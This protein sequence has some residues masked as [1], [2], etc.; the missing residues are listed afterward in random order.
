M[1]VSP[2]HGQWITVGLVCVSMAAWAETE[3]TPEVSPTEIIRRSHD[4][5][6]DQSSYATVAMEIARP[7]WS[8]K[9]IMQAWTR[10]TDET[11]IHVLEPRKDKGIKFLKKG[12]EG[13]NYIPSIDRIVKIPP[14]MMLQSWMGSDFTNDDI[15]R[16]DSIVTDYDHTISKEFTED[17]EDCWSIQALAREDAAVVWGKV[18]FTVI[19]RNLVAK[20]IEYWDEDGQLVKYCETSGVRK[21][22][23]RDVPLRFAMYDLTREGYSTTIL[24]SDLTFS[25]DIGPDLFTL[26]NLRR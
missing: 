17:G 13:W 12:R 23:G 20:R 7:K 11:F 18:L 8:R 4:L 6:R 5:L 10:G 15:V 2:R 9:L 14:S 25:P 3:G 21:I 19:K 22:E 26:R 16:A 24:Y 1:N